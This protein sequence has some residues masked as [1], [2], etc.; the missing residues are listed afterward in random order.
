LFFFNFKSTTTSNK[1]VDNL[2]VR[3][4]VTNSENR[5]MVKIIVNIANKIQIK[6]N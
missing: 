5:L 4:A 2:S 3:L 1:S 6:L